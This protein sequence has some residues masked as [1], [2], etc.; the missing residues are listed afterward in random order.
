MG[1]EWQLEATH[2]TPWAGASFATTPYTAIQ[3]LVIG[4]V[5]SGLRIE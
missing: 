2:V 3:H 4:Q 1:Y 5:I